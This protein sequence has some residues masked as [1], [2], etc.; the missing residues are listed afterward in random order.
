MFA[1]SSI[2]I[3][4]LYLILIDFYSTFRIKIVRNW[5]VILMHNQILNSENFYAFLECSWKIVII[6]LALSILFL[7]EGLPK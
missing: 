6:A 3:I 4:F 7:I 2:W 5:R 1:L